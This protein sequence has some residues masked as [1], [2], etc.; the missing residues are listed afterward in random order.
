MSLSKMA[1]DEECLVKINHW[2]LQENPEGSLFGFPLQ[3]SDPLVLI[4]RLPLQWPNG[5]WL[6]CWHH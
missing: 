3:V 1:E 4:I 5:P 2:T 6:G